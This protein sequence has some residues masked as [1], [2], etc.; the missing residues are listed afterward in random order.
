MNAEDPKPGFKADSGKVRLELLPPEAIMWIGRALTYG[1][2]KY[3]HLPPDNWRRVAFGRPRYF[4]A[5]LR[6]TFAA[7]AGEHLD[8]ESGLPHLAH[9]GACVVFLLCPL[10]GDDEEIAEILTSRP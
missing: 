6:H 9:A 4:G 8:E 2:Q 10:A 7:L 3:E 1:A 5:L